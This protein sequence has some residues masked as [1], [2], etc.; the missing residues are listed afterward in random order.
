MRLVRC[1]S[2]ER[3]VRRASGNTSGFHSLEQTPLPCR[4]VPRRRE[5]HE[6]HDVWQAIAVVKVRVTKH[7]SISSC[8]ASQDSGSYCYTSGCKRWIIDY[9][10]YIAGGWTR[11]VTGRHCRRILGA[12]LPLSSTIDCGKPRVPLGQLSQRFSR[13]P[14]CASRRPHKAQAITANR[15]CEVNVN[16]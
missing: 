3:H 11:A 15:M 2:L 8:I 10:L 13:I 16:K 12:L 4:T 1:S 7:V 6:R 14:N 9:L 5:A